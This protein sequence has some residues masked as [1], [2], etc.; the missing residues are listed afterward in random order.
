MI[1]AAADGWQAVKLQSLHLGPNDHG[2]FARETLLQ[3]T[4]LTTVESLMLSNCRLGE[5][6]PHLLAAALRAMRNLSSLSLYDVQWGTPEDAAA[7]ANG[8]ALLLRGLVNQRRWLSQIKGL[9]FIKQHVGRAAATALSKMR[10]LQDL[11]FIECQIEDS[12]IAEI[13][14]GLKPWL[15]RLGLPLNQQLTDA[16]LPALA[17]A[18]PDVDES[19]FRGCSGITKKGLRRYILGVDGDSESASENGSDSGSDSE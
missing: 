11:T 18:M 19:C 4:R 13:A 2:S 8:L 1:K 6:E 7:S 5:L 9:W 14:L 3:L 10:G 15:Q 16:C 12:S 17:Y